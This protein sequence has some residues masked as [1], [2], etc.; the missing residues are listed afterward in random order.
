MKKKK[1]LTKKQVTAQEFTNV[2]DIKNNLLYTRDGQV[3]AYMQILPISIGLLSSH[4]KQTLIKQLTAELSVEKEPFHFLALSRPVDV[5]PLL[6]QYIQLRNQTNNTY[7]KDLLRKEIE[8]ISEFGF[9]GEVVERQFYFYVSMSLSDDVEKDLKKRIHDFQEHFE[10][11]GI[12]TQR[13]HNTEIIRLCNLVN[14]PATVAIE[15][16][17]YEVTIPFLKEED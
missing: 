11:A 16:E 9:E 6:E 12:K 17:S 13:L 5:Q 4:E 8:N 3:I 1:K 10:A 15:D 7:Q 2:Q 14:N